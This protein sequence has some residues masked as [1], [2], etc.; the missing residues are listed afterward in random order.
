MLSFQSVDSNQ[1][2]STVVVG[3]W[4][5]RAARVD[6]SPGH[7]IDDPTTSCCRVCPAPRPPS[8]RR[9]PDRPSSI[10]NSLFNSSPTRADIPLT[11]APSYCDCNLARDIISVFID[12][13]MSVFSWRFST[14]HLILIPK[15]SGTIKVWKFSLFKSLRIELT[16]VWFWK[17][18]LIVNFIFVF[19]VLHTESYSYF[20]R[21][22]L[23]RQVVRPSIC[24]SVPNV[25]ERL[26]RMLEYFENNFTAEAKNHSAQTGVTYKFELIFYY[27]YTIAST[28]LCIASH[29]RHYEGRSK[30]S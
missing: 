13:P 20:Y 26:S 11:T 28:A 30:S 23:V 1:R 14:S 15:I 19:V 10:D 12:R 22:M 27:S 18:S 3:S 29:V 25:E 5:N 7:L 4:S 21:A 9:S 6:R 24:P 17:Q 2:L 16:I 8:S